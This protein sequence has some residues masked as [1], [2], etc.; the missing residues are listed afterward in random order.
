[1]APNFSIQ[2]SSVLSFDCFFLFFLCT[3]T[4]QYC[5]KNMFSNW[6]LY[7]CL[8]SAFYEYYVSMNVWSKVFPYTHRTHM[9]RAANFLQ[10]YTI[11]TYKNWKT[12]CFSAKFRNKIMI[13][14]LLTLQRDHVFHFG[15][16]SRKIRNVNIGS[17][18]RLYVCMYISIRTHYS[19]CSFKSIF[20]KINMTGA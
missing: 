7:L 11:V 8:P 3:F 19:G 2:E 18:G 13:L 20:M 15:G 5:C 10:Y 6:E 9:R 1:M 4:T 17:N 16:P 14:T 12:T